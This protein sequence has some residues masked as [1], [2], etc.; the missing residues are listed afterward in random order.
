MRG[1]PGKWQSVDFLDVNVEG[2][3]YAHQPPPSVLQAE[4]FRGLF[5]PSAPE[6]S[7]PRQA[8]NGDMTWHISDDTAIISDVQWN[9]D[10]H[11]LAIAEAGLAISRGSRLSYYI[12]DSY[13][14]ALESQVLSFNA[15]YNLTNKYN[16]NFN[17]SLDFGLSRAEVTYLTV[18]RRFDVFSISVSVYHDE[19]NRVNGFNVNLF[20]AGQP[21]FSAPWNVND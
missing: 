2:D 20:P 18:T 9:M 19:I 13:I 11:E 7:V 10:K 14:Q 1:G 15:N 6:T 21:G 4:S 16:L 8:I 17:Q 12:G 5:F 3:F